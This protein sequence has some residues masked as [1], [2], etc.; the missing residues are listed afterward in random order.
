MNDNIG[1]VDDHV[2]VLAKDVKAAT[3]QP[4]LHVNRIVQG[5]TVL[6]EA[7]GE[8]DLGTASMLDQQL[9]Y[10]EAATVAPAPVIVDL[11]RVAF[12]GARGL[13]VRPPPSPPLPLAGQHAADRGPAALR[14]QT[15][16]DRR[17]RHHPV[18]VPQHHRRPA[19]RR[20]N[21]TA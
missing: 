10:A 17:P 2:G 15:D 21:R 19:E 12:L 18:R 1:P 5:H 9:A 16:P 8:I 6:I 13:G 14:A 3:G 20:M 4:P 11:T 7:G